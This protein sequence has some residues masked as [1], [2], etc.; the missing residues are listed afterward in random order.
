M[1]SDTL[2]LANDL[3]EV[4]V[5]PS[6][7]GRVT[8]LVDRLSGA[9]RVQPPPGLGEVLAEGGHAPFFG[10]D[11]W[12]K[13]GDLVDPNTGVLSTFAP[14]RGQ[15]MT[16]RS[17]PGR[18]EL[19][20]RHGGLRMTLEWALPSG[21]S[22][23]SCRMTLVNES[24]PPETFQ[25]EGFFIW[26]LPAQDW[27]A[28]ALAL[29]GHAPVAMA[30]YGEIVFE[31]G[32]SSPGCAVLWKRA[33]S[34]GVVMRGGKG[35]GRFF[36]G[37]Q[38]G[39]VILGPHSQARRLEPGQS[40]VAGFEIAPL[41]W[42]QGQAWPCKT[43]EAEKE[44]AAREKQTA[45]LARRVGSV[46]QWVGPGREPLARR[47]LHLTLQYR[48]TELHAALEV[49]EKLVA[50]AGYNEL[51]VE[52]DRA[53]PYRSHPKVSAPWA[54]TAAQWREFVRA[55]RGLGMELVPQYNALAHQ[56]E[57]GLAPA[58]RELWEDP[59]GW[60]LCPSHPN[61][62][63]YLC[64]L[65]DELIEVFAPKVFHIGLDE[66]DMPSRPQSFGLCPRC[67][68]GDGGE[69]LGNHILALHEHLRAA[70]IETMMWG[71][72]LLHKP[73]HNTTNGLRCGTWRA[74]DRLPREIIMVD[75]VYS[76]VKDYGGAKYFM[77]KG[78]RVMGATWHDPR[79]VPPFARFAAA[80]N[81]YGMCETTWSSPTFR[82]MPMVCVL[83]A[84][85]YFRNPRL[86]NFEQ[87]VAEAKAVAA[88]LARNG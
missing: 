36:Y 83:T 16:A 19:E 55:A 3:W 40:L 41:F 34:A 27:D 8:R 22:P 7:G 61:T 38:A 75:W 72:M 44:L 5:S 60:C 52:V 13:C 28:T 70:G 9:V 17:A 87:T 85:K 39:T 43:P 86:E 82:A 47:M 48:P 59:H 81:L 57:S 18:V 69:L 35:L 84:G 58:Y 80:N 33:T 23:L 12:C 45:D 71:D 30:P 76:P 29:P 53:F 24:A 20:S 11:L 26:Q 31:A 46:S 77:E 65:F 14:I 88:A 42:A 25:F 79:S 10:L 78:F 6:L 2:R 64:E 32:D 4:E 62:K 66:I 21:K 54:W 73:E 68:G 37:V 1:A 63:K 67:Q 15:A 56:G 50:P 51:S 49:L 74:L